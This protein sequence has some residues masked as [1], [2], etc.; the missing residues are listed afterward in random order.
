MEHYKDLNDMLTKSAQAYKFYS[1]LPYDVQQMIDESKHGIYTE[2]DL[3]N[4][5]ENIGMHNL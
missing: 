5:V 2:N 3:R 4:Y 1:D